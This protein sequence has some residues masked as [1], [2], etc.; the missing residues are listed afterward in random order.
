MWRG[1]DAETSTSGSR[2]TLVVV[3]G[4]GSGGRSA[5][6]NAATPVSGLGSTLVPIEDGS[7]AEWVS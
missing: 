7:D 1:G 4:E 5:L 6:G 3:G 2:P